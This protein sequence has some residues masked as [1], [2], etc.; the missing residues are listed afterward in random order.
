[1]TT[2]P[3]RGLIP[4]ITDVLE[5]LTASE[6]V[7]LFHLHRLRLERMTF[8][9]PPVSLFP[10]EP[11]S[12]QSRLG[13]RADAGGIDFDVSERPEHSPTGAPNWPTTQDEDVVAPVRVVDPLPGPSS[14]QQDPPYESAHG[15]LHAVTA[16]PAQARARKVDWPTA[17]DEK[18]LETLAV[19]RD[20]DYFAEL[21]QKLAELNDGR[22]G[23]GAV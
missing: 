11:R 2:T 16:V 21:D 17:P 4:E 8:S 3:R 9:A 22:G 23:D 15:L 14:Q 19:R 7:L 5:R 13:P 20:Y 6:E 18:S 12:P 1:M 10:Q